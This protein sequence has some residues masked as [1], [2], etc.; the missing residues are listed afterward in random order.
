[1]IDRLVAVQLVT[2]LYVR[3]AY[4]S[5]LAAYISLGGDRLISAADNDP[6]RCQ[7]IEWPTE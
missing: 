7:V 2:V 4:E 3:I 5:V 1:M 6:V